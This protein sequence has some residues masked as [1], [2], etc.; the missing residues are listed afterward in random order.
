MDKQIEIRSS[1]TIKP[2]PDCKP[3]KHRA[4]AGFSEAELIERHTIGEYND[5]E[6]EGKKEKEEADSN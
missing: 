2:S 5:E 3:I 4:I 1:V 6:E